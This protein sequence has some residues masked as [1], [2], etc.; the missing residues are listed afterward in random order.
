M[1]DQTVL[2]RMFQP[3]IMIP[4]LMMKTVYSSMISKKSDYDTKNSES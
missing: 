3:Q 2:K 4:S 1:V